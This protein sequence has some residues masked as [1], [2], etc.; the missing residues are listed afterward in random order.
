MTKLSPYL[1]KSMKLL[2]PELPARLEV[3][4]TTICRSDGTLKMQNQKLE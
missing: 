1:A 3:K 4:P 2:M